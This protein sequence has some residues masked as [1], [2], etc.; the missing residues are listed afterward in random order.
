MVRLAS[1]T[2]KSHEFHPNSLQVSLAEIAR[3]S[4]GD[5]N[6][7]AQALEEVWK[8]EINH[9]MADGIMTQIR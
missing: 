3:R 6:T 1:G 8:R 9:A 2:A 5:A 4:Y 7:V